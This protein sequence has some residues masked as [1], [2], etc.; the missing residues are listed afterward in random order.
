M[1]CHPQSELATNIAKTDHSSEMKIL[2]A[3]ISAERGFA[4]QKYE[5]TCNGGC[6]SGW[7]SSAAL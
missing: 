6:I 7:A 1:Q 4:L 5:A 3:K 2:L